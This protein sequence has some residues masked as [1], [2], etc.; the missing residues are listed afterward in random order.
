MMLMHSNGYF[1]SYLQYIILEA[2]SLILIPI[3]DQE[4]VIIIYIITSDP[5]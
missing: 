3:K 1:Q 5:E 2:A 4:N